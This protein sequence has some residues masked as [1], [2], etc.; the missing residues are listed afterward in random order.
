MTWYIIHPDIDKYYTKCPKKI[1]LKEAVLLLSKCPWAEDLDVGL[2]GWNWP[3]RE[4][5]L[6]ICLSSDPRGIFVF[7]NK[8]LTIDCQ[9]KFVHLHLSHTRQNNNIRAGLFKETGLPSWLPRQQHCC[10]ADLWIQR[11]PKS[12]KTLRS[13]QMWAFWISNISSRRLLG[14]FSQCKLYSICKTL[15]KG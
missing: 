5:T 14:K 1:R 2:S 6:N 13:Q 12:N 7:S 15:G 8:I 10:I 11:S 4:F 3:G 9:H